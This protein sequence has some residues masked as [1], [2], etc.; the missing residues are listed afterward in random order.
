M[1]SLLLRLNNTCVVLV[2]IFIE[3][4]FSMRRDYQLTNLGIML[5]SAMH[6]TV[7]RIYDYMRLSKVDVRC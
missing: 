2:C 3:T 1:P 4:I 7:I 6:L 5:N